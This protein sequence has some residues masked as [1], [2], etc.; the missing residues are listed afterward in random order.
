MS[1]ELVGLAIIAVLALDIWAVIS[2]VNSRVPTH[3]KVL[4]SSVILVFPIAGF[5][6]WLAVGPRETVYPF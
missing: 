5:L 3:R 6:A 4:W 2:V 1:I